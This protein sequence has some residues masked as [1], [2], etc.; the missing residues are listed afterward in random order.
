[1][2]AAGATGEPG[3][4]PCGLRGPFACLAANSGRWKDRA[5][6]DQR[7]AQVTRSS[8][9]DASRRR[10][11]RALAGG[12]LAGLVGLRDQAPV[13]AARQQVASCEASTGF[14]A[15][16]GDDRYAQS[17]TPTLG[18]KLSRV[19]VQVRKFK[20]TTGSYFLQI[21]NMVA[22]K[23]DP[24]PA[25][26]LATA[27]IGNR[28]VR[29]SLQRTLTF[30]FAKDKAA[31]VQAGTEYAFIITRPGSTNLTVFGINGNPCAGQGFFFDASTGQFA[32]FGTMDFDFEA[33]IGSS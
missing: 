20:G 30:D 9:R 29:P 31:T 22:G 13:A 8:V 26:V 18:G 6:D 33:F 1:M 14:V 5:M 19:R 7:C 17:F 15:G 3:W 10:L 4:D 2:V 25:N 27:K 11:L 21:V 28:K 24:D 16:D 32:A 23:P 12:G